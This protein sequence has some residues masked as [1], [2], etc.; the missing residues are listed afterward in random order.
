[1]QI[2]TTFTTFFDSGKSIAVS[3]TTRVRPRMGDE[4]SHRSPL[5]AESGNA[6]ETALLWIC[7]TALAAV[8]RRRTVAIAKPAN[9]FETLRIAIDPIRTVG[10]QFQPKIKPHWMTRINMAVARAGFLQA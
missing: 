8:D 5:S 2:H 10:P 6:N 7:Q 9:G 1:M 3:V 4:L